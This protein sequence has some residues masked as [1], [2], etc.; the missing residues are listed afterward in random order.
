MPEAEWQTR[1]LR[2]HATLRALQPAWTN[3]REIVPLVEG[4]EEVEK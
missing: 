1:K 3:L 2:I 4:E